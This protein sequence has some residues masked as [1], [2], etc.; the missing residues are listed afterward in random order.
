MSE[1]LNQTLMFV[2]MQVASAYATNCPKG[3]DFGEATRLI[4][5]GFTA[6]ARGDPIAAPPHPLSYLPSRRH[7]NRRSWRKVV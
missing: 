6:A 5:A 2:T 4:G 1:P 3:T 7:N